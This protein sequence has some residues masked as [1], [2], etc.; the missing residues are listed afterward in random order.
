MCRFPSLNKLFI[1]KSKVFHLNIYENPLLTYAQISK[2]HPLYQLNIQKN[3]NLKNVEIFKSGVSGI[4]IDQKLNSLN[5][6]R[7]DHLTK[8]DGPTEK[9]K[10]HIH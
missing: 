3:G 9:D 5:L 2:C 1:H 10:I 6:I 8:V 7:C 4:F